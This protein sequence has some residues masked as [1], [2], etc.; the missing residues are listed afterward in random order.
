MTTAPLKSSP[1]QP[2]NQLPPPTLCAAG[3]KLPLFSSQVR[4]LLTFPSSTSFMETVPLPTSVKSNPPSEL[5]TRLQSFL[6]SEWQR[7]NTPQGL[8]AAWA[9]S[10]TATCDITSKIFRV[11]GFKAW[12][13]FYLATHEAGSHHK[14]KKI[15][16]AIKN[17][18]DQ[19]S[20]NELKEIANKLKDTAAHYTVEQA[21]KKMS[22]RES[23]SLA[24]FKCLQL[25]RCNSTRMEILL[26]LQQRHQALLRLRSLP[27]RLRCRPAR[28]L[29]QLRTEVSW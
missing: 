27:Q 2:C 6:T 10:S 13:A 20:E 7:R 8:K 16:S 9:D 1:L 21:I 24:Y 23:M 5:E 29:A 17:A 18:L 26:Y 19:L 12:L 4:E 14:G 25:Q 15:G 22:T 11:S 28:R 3:K